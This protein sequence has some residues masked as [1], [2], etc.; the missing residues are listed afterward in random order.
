MRGL[1]ATNLLQAR[2][3]TQQYFVVVV[4]KKGAL[5]ARFPFD[6]VLGKLFNVKAQYCTI[7]DPRIHK[8]YY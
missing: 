7:I 4:L 2:I 1:L 6:G 3:V 8:S 5:L